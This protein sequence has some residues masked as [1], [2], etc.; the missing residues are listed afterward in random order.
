MINTLKVATSGYL[1]R[2][3]KS[4]LV[5][6]TAGYLNFSEV[7]VSTPTIEY[8]GRGI[9]EQPYQKSPKKKQQRQIK[10]TVII[11]GIEYIETKPVKKYKTSVKD[12]VI[13][14]DGSVSFPIIDVEVLN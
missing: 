14:S 6:A 10:V 12:A 4:A 1:K 3:V 11:D 13:K 5:I 2:T 7:V 8:G 9:I